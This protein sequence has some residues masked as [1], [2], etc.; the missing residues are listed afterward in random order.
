MNQ[1]IAKIPNINFSPK[2]QQHEKDF[3]VAGTG[4]KIKDLTKVEIC[5]KLAD[6]LTKTIFDSGQSADKLKLTGT[7]NSV[8]P[9]LKR[10]FTTLTLSDLEHAFHLGVRK[11]FGEYMGINPVTIFNWLRQYV[12]SAKRNEA[13]KKQA[14]YLE[15][16]NKPKPIS[17]IE[18]E[19][20]MQTATLK[21]F[22]DVKKGVEFNDIGNSIYDYLNKKGMIPFTKERKETIMKIAQKNV[23][24]RL[25]NNLHTSKSLA[26]KNSIKNALSTIEKEAGNDVVVEAK[27]IALVEYFK[28]LIEMNEILKF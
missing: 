6:V 9:D 8:Y 10:Y 14:E 7:I 26:E 3:I 20:I 13:K 12:Q 22:E 28:E 23:K 21:A 11:E 1:Q 2:L 19:N 27:K 24:E 4:K 5:T 18:K 17:E 15:S 16:L 25:V